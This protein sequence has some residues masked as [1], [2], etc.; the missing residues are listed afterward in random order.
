MVLSDRRANGNLVHFR[1]AADFGGLLLHDVWVLRCRKISDFAWFPRSN[2]PTIV[3]APAVDFCSSDNTSINLCDSS[4]SQSHR[5]RSQRRIVQYLAETQR[6]GRRIR[7]LW[8]TNNCVGISS[9]TRWHASRNSQYRFDD[10]PLFSASDLV[11]KSIMVGSRLVLYCCL[12][13]AVCY[14][15]SKIHHLS[16]SRYPAGSELHRSP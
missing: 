2:S 4:I 8:S 6:S 9:A 15:Q 7:S 16:A 1:L 3:D 14:Q 11:I 12:L 10:Y 13:L 5:I